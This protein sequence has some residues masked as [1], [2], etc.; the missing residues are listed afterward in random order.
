MD[1]INDT[2]ATITTKQSQQKSISQR[3]MLDFIEQTKKNEREEEWDSNLRCRNIIIHGKCEG[4][5]S[6][7][8]D[9]MFVKSVMNDIG[10]YEVNPKCILR[11]GVSTN[12]LL[13]VVLKSSKCRD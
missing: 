7:E 13:K 4:G 5:S 8:T 6:S 12:R 9:Q 2:Y 11:L 1:V 3:H 10:L